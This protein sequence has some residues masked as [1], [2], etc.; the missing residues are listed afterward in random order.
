MSSIVYQT[1]PV[2]GVKYAYESVSYWD[3]DKKAPRSKRKYIGRVDPETGEIIKGA[4]K[5]KSSVQA[6]EDASGNSMNLQEQLEK[7]DTEIAELRKELEEMT[8][9]LNKAER[10]LKEIRILMDTGGNT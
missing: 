9:R 7:K 2:T 3:K 8:V 5:K 1:N 6:A 4:G 10:I